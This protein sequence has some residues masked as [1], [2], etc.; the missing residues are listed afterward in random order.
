MNPIQHSF[1]TLEPS[2]DFEKKVM[3]AVGKK[4]SRHMTRKTVLAVAV[5]ICLV[6]SVAAAGVGVYISARRDMELNGTIY[7]EIEVA[8]NLEPQNIRPEAL[9]Q[10]Q[11]V[12]GNFYSGDYLS[13]CVPQDSFRTFSTLEEV[14]TFLGI[15]LL[16]SPAID[17][18]TKY[19]TLYPEF[20]AEDSTD[21]ALAGTT[22]AP[23]G[24]VISI[25]LTGR[26]GVYIYVA[27]TQEKSAVAVAPFASAKEDGGWVSETF[28]L[29]ETLSGILLTQENA[30]LESRNRSAAGLALTYNGVGYCFWY[31]SYE[32]DDVSEARSKVISIAEGLN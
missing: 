12:W 4:S 31:S 2:G 18:E 24:L 10:L 11:G 20:L 29:D 6:I 26:Y 21:N 13:P 15:D 1:Q 19:I 28:Q 7:H 22:I 5:V 16:H 3:E 27:L 17:K 23:D 8:M 32:N 30:G 9:E 25:H 14:E